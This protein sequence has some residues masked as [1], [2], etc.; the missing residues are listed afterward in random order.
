MT[1]REATRAWLDL[2]RASNAIKK[3]VDTAFKAEFG[4][5][6][7]RFDIM[8]TLARSGAQGLRAGELSQQLMVTEGNT[9]QVTAPLIRDGLVRRRTS[10][11]DARVAIFTLTKKGERLFEQMA[12]AHHAW[13]S[14]TF[15]AF[16]GADLTTLRTLLGRLSAPSTFV[17]SEAKDS[18]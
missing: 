11:E 17:L 15:A 5:S 8:A 10:S 2:L 13:I 16:S 14:K 3:S 7:S 18:A 4:L 9:T 6:L 12:E 1:D